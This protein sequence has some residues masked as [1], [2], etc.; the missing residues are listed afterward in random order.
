[1][2]HLPFTCDTVILSVVENN[3][4]SVVEIWTSTSVSI[5]TSAERLHSGKELL[6]DCVHEW[7]AGCGRSL[8]ISMCS[9]SAVQFHSSNLNIEFKD[10]SVSIEKA[11]MMF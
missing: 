4:A 11:S 1:M 7:R 3:G 10:R 5:R 6:K 8:Y 2:P 9:S